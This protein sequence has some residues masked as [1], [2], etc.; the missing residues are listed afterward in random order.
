MHCRPIERSSALQRIQRVFTTVL[1][2]IPG[3]GLKR[4]DDFPSSWCDFYIK[5]PTYHDEK[6]S[7]YLKISASP[8]DDNLYETTLLKHCYEKS[9]N[10]E[11]NCNYDISQQCNLCHPEPLVRYKSFESLID[12]VTRI[13]ECKN[14]QHFKSDLEYETYHNIVGMS[15]VIMCFRSF[16]GPNV[17]ICGDSKASIE[18]PVVVHTNQSL[19]TN[20]SKDHRS[21]MV[22]S[23]KCTNKNILYNFQRRHI[24][25]DCLVGDLVKNMPSH[26]VSKINNINEG[27]ENY[28]GN[29]DDEGDEGDEGDYTD[30]E[31]DE[32]EDDNESDELKE[33]YAIDRAKQAYQYLCEAQ[34]DCEYPPDPP[35]TY[36]FELELLEEFNSGERKDRVDTI[37]IHIDPE[38]PGL[39]H[40]S[41]LDINIEQTFCCSDP[42]CPNRSE[43][44]CNNLPD[45]LNIVE[46]IIQGTFNKNCK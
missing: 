14:V 35:T 13:F 16:T 5:I 4:L 39:Y 24:L 38:S 32:N 40:V 1:Q 46:S 18:N 45:L 26:H 37:I 12:S 20:V 42:Q 8:M 25:F 10:K 41:L 43:I 31:Y 30:I 34:I 27:D 9:D 6:S 33:I 23:T 2:Q 36:G 22:C 21:S 7:Q 19:S 15:N 11:E 28:E 44:N 17:L 3:T 29:E